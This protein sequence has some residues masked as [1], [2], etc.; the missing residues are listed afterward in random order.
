MTTTME[1]MVLQ[2]SPE[3]QAVAAKSTPKRSA[4]YVK[5]TDGSL[6]PEEDA[7]RE[8]QS[9]VLMVLRRYGPQLIV[10]IRAMLSWGFFVSDTPRGQ[11]AEVS[12]ALRAL[13][14]Q[15]FV[16][17]TGHIPYTWAAVPQEAT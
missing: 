15:G 9:G 3:R 16:T 5:R 14:E 13:F 7:R 11:S 2:P 17:K 4:R 1:W 12:G 6:L 10:N 8:L